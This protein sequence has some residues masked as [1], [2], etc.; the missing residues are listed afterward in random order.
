MYFIITRRKLPLNP[1]SLYKSGC[2]NYNVCFVENDCVVLEIFIFL[3][4]KSSGTAVFQQFQTAVIY[5]FF[6]TFLAVKTLP[7]CKLVICI[8]AFQWQFTAVLQHSHFFNSKQGRNIYELIKKQQFS[9]NIKMR[10]ETA[11]NCYHLIYIHQNC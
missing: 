10:T 7:F 1:L 4:P 6:V 8:K 3:L 9:M 2:L 5:K 11:L